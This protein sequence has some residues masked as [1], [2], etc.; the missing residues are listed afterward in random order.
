MPSESGGRPY[1]QPLPVFAE[2]LLKFCKGHSGPYDNHLI[3][4]IK[5][6]D[7]IQRRAVQAVYRALREVTEIFA[8]S[9]AQRQNRL[10]F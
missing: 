8:G 7:V 3:Q 6:D 10:F 9:A 1:R 2:S 5:F 4:R